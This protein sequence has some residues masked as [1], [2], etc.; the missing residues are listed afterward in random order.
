MSRSSSWGN[1]TSV[2]RSGVT[3]AQTPAR[4]L[5]PRSVCTVSDVFA[6]W[7]GLVFRC[8]GRPLRPRLRNASIRS[9]LEGAASIPA[10]LRGHGVATQAAESPGASRWVTPTRSAVMTPSGLL[11]GRLRTRLYSSVHVCAPHRKVGLG[12]ARRISAV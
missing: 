6:F 7:G 1:E 9:I 2:L 4:S 12:V 3:S 10:I 11:Q 8:R 5:G